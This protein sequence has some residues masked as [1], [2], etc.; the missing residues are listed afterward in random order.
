MTVRLTKFFNIHYKI[1]LSKRHCLKTHL[2]LPSSGIH[3]GK[4][5]RPVPPE[6]R[7]A[8]EVCHCAQCHTHSSQ[9]GYWEPEHTRFAQLIPADTCVQAFSR[10]KRSALGPEPGLPE[11]TTGPWHRGTGPHWQRTPE[12]RRAG[13][14]TQKFRIGSKHGAI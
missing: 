11:L 7:P 9:G 1:N 6:S 12:T 13:A 5:S 14:G 3:P 4:G 2:V 8:L 10:P